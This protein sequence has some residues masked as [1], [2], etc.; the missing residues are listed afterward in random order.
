MEVL[1]PPAFSDCTL[2]PLTPTP[3]PA[4]WTDQTGPNSVPVT[5]SLL[6]QSLCRA[7]GSRSVRIGDP[8]GKGDPDVEG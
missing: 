1:N 6:S 5:L 4:D 8:A 3:D 7:G 2:G